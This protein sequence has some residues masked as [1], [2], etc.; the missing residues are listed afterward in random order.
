MIGKFRRRAHR[1]TMTG[2]CGEVNGIAGAAGLRRA[3]RRPLRLKQAEQ[4]LI[5]DLE[6]PAD[7]SYIVGWVE[8]ARP[9]GIARTYCKSKNRW[10]RNPRVPVGLA[11]ARPTLQQVSRGARST[12]VP[13]H[14]ANPRTDG[15]GS[16]ARRARYARPTL[17]QDE[18]LAETADSTRVAPRD[19]YARRLEAARAEK[20]RLDGR[21]SLLGN[22]RV[23]VFFAGLVFLY[24]VFWARLISPWWLLLPVGT[25]LFILQRY[26]RLMRALVLA[27]SRHCLLR[28]RARPHPGRLGRQRRSRHRLPE[29]ASPVCAG[30]RSVRRGSFLSV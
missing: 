14:I 27:E 18:P 8:R 3:R 23:L 7:A 1:I 11:Y 28:K 9:T 4:T 19:E 6:T 15:I 30:P 12:G 16:P 17:Q 25:F 26:D 29:R 13:G 10:D 5:P 22:A 24:V 21:E 20:T 2:G